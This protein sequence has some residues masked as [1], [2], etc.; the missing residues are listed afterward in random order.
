MGRLMQAVSRLYVDAN[1][2]IHLVEHSD[3]LAA[4]L[5]DLFT[6]QTSGR[7]FLV[8]SELTLAEVLV[9]PYRATNDRLIDRDDAATI[10]NSQLDVG[11]VVR[12]VLWYAAVLRSQYNSLKTPNAI[13]VSTAI[14]MQ[15][16]HF[17]TADKRLANRYELTHHRYGLVKGPATVDVIRPELEVVRQLI[18]VASA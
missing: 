11:P 15:F 12:P 7:P 16:S 13:H 17:L 2:L 10:P 14:G 9:G 8:T 6:A 18:E 3:G 4:A 5:T 1:I